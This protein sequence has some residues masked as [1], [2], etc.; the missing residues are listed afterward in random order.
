VSLKAVSGGL[1]E[2]FIYVVVWWLLSDREP[3]SE[4]NMIRLRAVGWIVALA[5]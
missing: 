4:I 5:R 1:H 3:L 2:F